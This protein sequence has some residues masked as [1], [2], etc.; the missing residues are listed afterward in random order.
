MPFLDKS[1][2]ILSLIRGKTIVFA[3][4]LGLLIFGVIT[5]DFVEIWRNGATI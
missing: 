5:G 3:L 4:L 1:L 2:L